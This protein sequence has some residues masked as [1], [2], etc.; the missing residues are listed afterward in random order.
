MVASDLLDDVVNVLFVS[1]FM[2]GVDAVL[3]VVIASRELC[4]VVRCLSVR[5]LELI[6]N[7]SVSRV[8]RFLVFIIAQIFVIRAVISG[9][10]GMFARK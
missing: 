4:I 10:L 3:I 6:V 7:T 1:G 9:A 8:A 5:L 2:V